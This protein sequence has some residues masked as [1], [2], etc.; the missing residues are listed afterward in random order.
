MQALDT[1]G[2]ERCFV[3]SFTALRE[4]NIQ[5]ARL[6]LKKD[7]LTK[8]IID[9]LD[10]KHEGQKTY[11]Y[12]VWK[13]EVKTPCIYSLNKQKLESGNFKLPGRWNPVKQ[14]IAYSIDKRL[15]DQYLEEAPDEVREILVDLIDKKPGK[16]TVLVKERV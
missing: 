6:L 9:T 8:T 7:E 12:G 3:D 15:C 11:E 16:A 14:S 13:I 2:Q 5:L 1:T 4:V 10:H